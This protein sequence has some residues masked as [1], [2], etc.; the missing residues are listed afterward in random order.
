MRIDIWSDVVC[1]WCFL[2]KRRFEQALARLPWGAEIEVRWRAFQLDPT[3]GPEPGDLR[4]ALEAKYGPGAFDGMT[5]RLTDLGAEEGITYRFDRALRVGT[6]PAHRLVAW[7]W[8]AGGAAVQG[9]VV[10]ALFRG[11]F[12]DGA[13]VGAAATL[14]AAA[15]AAGLD[16]ARAA[17][18][19][20]SD[21]YADEVA[22]DRR[23]AAEREIT[24]VPAF[25]I[26]DRFMIAGAQDVDTMVLVL[27]RARQRLAADA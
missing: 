14:V 21:A 7:A 4:A 22:A 9:A 25:V 12:E 2:G 1:P 23:G 6:L 24:G 27:E 13:D 8:D 16:P 11:Y 10:E 17:E 20:A 15:A 18:I 19:V 26:E 5:R 3:A